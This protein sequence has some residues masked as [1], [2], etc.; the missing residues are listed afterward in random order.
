MVKEATWLVICRHRP[1]DPASD[2]RRRWLF[3]RNDHLLRNS[4][5][6]M[7]AHA[8]RRYFE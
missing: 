5:A 8:E 3:Y 2:T 1:P 7:A 6:I 4:E